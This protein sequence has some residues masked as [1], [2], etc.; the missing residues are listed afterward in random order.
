MQATPQ[1]R[2]CVERVFEQFDRITPNHQQL[3]MMETAKQAEA[4]STFKFGQMV[5]VC[6]PSGFSIKEMKSLPHDHSDPKQHFNSRVM[7]WDFLGRILVATQIH[8][9]PHCSEWPWTEDMVTACEDDVADWVGMSPMNIG[10]KFLFTWELRGFDWNKAG[11]EVPG[12]IKAAHIKQGDWQI[13]YAKPDGMWITRV[14]NE[15]H[16]RLYEANV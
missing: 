10:A 12:V 15:S 7:G 16:M 3:H 1:E 5:R 8:S 13:W 2:I 11:D 14:L 9:N 6:R 4:K